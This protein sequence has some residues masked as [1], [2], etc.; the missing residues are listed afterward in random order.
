M[1][2]E[3]CPKCGARKHQLNAC[4]QCTY[5]RSGAIDRKH[6]K[7]S[8]SK[9]IKTAKVNETTS[10]QVKPGTKRKKNRKKKA[11]NKKKKIILV[12]RRGARVAGRH[13][14]TNCVKI[15]D[16]PTR[17]AKS[18]RGAVVL[19]SIC[20]AKIRNYSFP[21]EKRDALDYA[22]TGGGFE[23]NRRRH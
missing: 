10:I 8:T 12:S 4:K 2:Y 7:H 5:T 16:N 17:Y 6:K 13:V 19:C 23:G 22:I 21:Q 14:C 1:A 3:F 11:Y 18:N 9:E 20:K 15:V